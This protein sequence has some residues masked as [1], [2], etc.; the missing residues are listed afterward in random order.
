MDHL[1]PIQA[2]KLLG[3]SIEHLALLEKQ[4]FIHS[5]HAAKGVRFYSLEE[6]TRI[7]SPRNLT[8]FEEAA[9]VETH[10]QRE[11]ASSV[12]FTRKALLL[13]VGVV[14]GYVLLVAVFAVFFIIAPLST[15]RFLG[16]VQERPET[17]V[18]QSEGLGKVLAATT[19][20]VFEKPSLLQTIFRPVGRVS[21]GIVRFANPRAYTEVAAVAILDPNDVLGLDTSGAIVPERPI[22][23]PD[24]SLL[25]VGSSGLVANLN[26]EYLQGRK[27]GTEV[28]DIALV[29]L[30]ASESS[31]EVSITAESNESPDFPD[32][33]IIDSDLTA[34]PD[35]LAGAGLQW[36][37]NAWICAVFPETLPTVGTA[38]TL[39][40]VTGRGAST[41][42]GL[43]FNGG[44]ITNAINSAT[45]NINFTINGTGSSGRVQLGNSG[46]ATPD[47]LVLD[48]GTAD[49]IGVSGGM[50]YNTST[51]KFRC[52]ENGVWANCIGLSSGLDLQ[53]AAS[54]DTDQEMTNVSAGGAQITLGTVTVTPGSA[55]GDVYVA[56]WAD[57]YSSNGEDQ[58]F[59]LVVETTS[60]C[61]GSTV[62]NA[63]VTYTLTTGAN[64]ANDRGSLRISGIAVDP[65]AS[66]Q[67]YS[68]C[69]SISSG[70]GDTDVLNWGMEA[71]VID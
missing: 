67:P 53:H 49:P 54:Y 46:T 52:H 32:T 58:P 19:N 62:G 13:A 59:H 16:Y 56:G 4:G 38:D 23:L 18:Y 3:V 28:G 26:S 44:I 40:S 60:N 68:L 47:L 24:S 11:M 37:G 34:L 70:G 8:V 6:I 33:G 9:L 22:K 15:A 21:L 30:S 29:T 71:V 35:C 66:A 31:P 1:S 51:D 43:T 48:N 5:V 36:N 7:K 27:P 55:T 10:I 39:A 25:Q 65:G 12:T 14:A 61:S 57:V 69:A 64:I 41:S 2:A 45:G 17:I 20:G 63:S 50:Y 42:T